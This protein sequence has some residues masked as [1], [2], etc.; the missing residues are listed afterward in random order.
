MQNPDSNLIFELTQ[1]EFDRQKNCLNL[2]A[3]ENIPSPKVLNLLGSVWSN[4][5]GEGYPGKRYYAGNQFTDTLESFVQKKALEV[6]DTRNRFGKKMKDGEIKEE[7]LGSTEDYAVNVQVLSGSPANA[8]VFLSVLDYGDK[9]LSLN[10][11]NGGHLSH[12]HATSNW[13]KFFKLVNYDVKLVEDFGQ[14][15]D[16]TEN[17]S[18]GLQTEK[19]SDLD[20]IIYKIETKFK[21]FQNQPNQN[22]NLISKKPFIIAIDGRG[23]SGKSTLA[24]ELAEKLNCELIPKDKYFYFEEN[25]DLSKEKVDTKDFSWKKEELE[26]DIKKSQ[27][28]VILVEGCGSFEI[29]SNLKIWMEMEEKTASKR[30]QKRNQKN[31]P[32]AN[33]KALKDIWR[34]IVA[35]QEKYITINIPKEQA[36]LVISTENGY[37]IVEKLGNLQ[38]KNQEN[39]FETNSKNQC[40]EIDEADFEAKLIEFKPKLTIL[41]ASSYPR[42]INFQKLTQI[43]HKHGSLVLADVAHINGLIAAGLH[44]SPFQSGEMSDSGADFVTMTTHKTLRGPRSAMIFMKKE[45]EKTIN[46]TIF[47]GTSGGP[48]FNKIAAIGQSCLEILGEDQYPDKT[49]FEKYS[50]NVLETCKALENSLAKNGLEIISPT[51]NHLCLVKLPKNSDSLEIQQKLE[52]IGIICNRNVLPFD[53]KSAW[54]PSGLRLGTAALTSRGLTVEMAKKMGKIISDL[55]F[56]RENEENLAKEVSNLIKKLSWFY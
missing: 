21:E 4:K 33:P 36:D 15:E 34:Q 55:I 31:F 49:P 52:K 45:W 56:E 27:K 9:I 46:K 38:Q 14:K 17:P 51:Q 24:K 18:L 3:S 39:N 13:N 44:F 47:P 37:E 26:N 32:D 53:Q 8:M 29:E 41:G 25:L 30:G 40:F 28:S 11:A 22:S 10:L 2:I 35:W 6:F 20:Q 48:H 19:N 43:A 12:L 23:G 42:L 1:S 5:Y 16:K 50:Q 7:F 54:R